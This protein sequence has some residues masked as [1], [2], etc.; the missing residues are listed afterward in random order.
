MPTI[1]AAQAY[2]NARSRL[3]GMQ[4]PFVDAYL[5][6]DKTAGNVQASGEAAGYK[7]R[8]AMTT[9][10]GWMPKPEHQRMLEH[11]ET[12][13]L[14]NVTIAILWGLKIKAEEVRKIEAGRSAKR[15]K[16]NITT[17]RVL[18]ALLENAER[19]S[20]YDIDQATGERKGT[21]DP[22][23]FVPST[24]QRS[25][26]LIGKDMGMFFDRGPGE[27]AKTFDEM[28]VDEL[29]A[30]M[31]AMDAQLAELESQRAADE[32]K[33]KKAKSVQH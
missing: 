12:H 32:K 6:G 5:F 30:E 25:W 27:K 7:K 20:G 4:G 10:S 2:A 23:A 29:N 1:D 13:N 17:E 24:A 21:F 26:E 8:S 9:V 33:S 16:L 3:R 18:Y 14:R 15:V 28:S 11:G 19:C 31:K 22:K